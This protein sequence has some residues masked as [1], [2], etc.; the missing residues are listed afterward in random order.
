M[1]TLTSLLV[2]QLRRG[3]AVLHQRC[4]GAPGAPRLGLLLHEAPPLEDVPHGTGE[5]EEGE[6]GGSRSTRCLRTRV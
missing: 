6:G 2:L 3:D 4:A 1:S 5:E